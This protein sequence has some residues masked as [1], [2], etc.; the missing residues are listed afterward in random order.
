MSGSTTRTW[1]LVAVTAG[2]WLLCVLPAWWIAGGSGVEGL[3]YA[4]LLCLVPGVVTLRLSRS[5]DS[6]RAPFVVLLS[7]GLRVAS[8]LAG[9]LVL[10]V[11]RPDLGPAAFHVWLIVGYLVTL[12]V[13]TRMLLAEMAVTRTDTSLGQ[14]AN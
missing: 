3:S 2:L 6:R 13:E 14:S 12:L 8:V 10:R 4:L 7:M 1:Q 5:V 9:V 11:L